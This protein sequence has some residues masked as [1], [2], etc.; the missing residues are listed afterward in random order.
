MRSR[1]RS[2]A[3]GSAGTLPR[4]GAAL[5]LVL[6]ALAA[7]AARAQLPDAIAALDAAP[8][9]TLHAEG[10]QIYECRAAPDGN[11]NWTFREPVASLMLDGRTVGRHYAGPTW[12]HGDG[13]SVTAKGV[14]TAPGATAA[15]IPWLKLDVV[16]RRGSGALTGADI[17]QRINTTGGVLH[18]SCERAGSLRAVAYAAD[19]VFRRKDR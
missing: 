9:L 15:D 18:G 14:G 7:D 19:Y 11:L 1:T 8:F 17:V 6:G 4:L 10:A 16:E 12:E 13:S 5:A 3:A 2:A